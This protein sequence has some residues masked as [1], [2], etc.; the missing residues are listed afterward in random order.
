MTA[1][2]IDFQ[3]RVRNYI[4]SEIIKQILVYHNLFLKT[5]IP[6]KDCQRHMFWIEQTYE[7]RNAAVI[8][9][10]GQIATDWW[11]H[12]K[13]TGHLQARMED[14]ARWVGPIKGNRN[15]SMIAAVLFNLT[16]TFKV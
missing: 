11:F 7:I 15:T 6:V 16:I 14:V 4:S 10:S 13:Y 5:T 12:N 9:L 3:V 1:P 8:A 2:Y